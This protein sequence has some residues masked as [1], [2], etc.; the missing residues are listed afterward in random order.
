MFDINELHG[1]EV[2]VDMPVGEKQEQSTKE[3]EVYTRV[4]VSDAPTTIEEITLAQTLIQIKSAKPKVVTTSTTTTTTTMPKARGKQ[5]EEANIA[6]I[7]SWDNTQAMMEADFEL[8]QRLQIEEQ[9]EIT[10][11]ER[12]RLYKHNQLKSKSFEEIQ[13][14]FDNEMSRVNTFIPMD[15]EEVKSKKGTE[16]SSKGTEDEQKSDKSKKAKSSREKAKGIRKKMLGKKR[17]R[18][19]QQQE[20]SKRQRMEDDKETDEHEEVKKLMKLV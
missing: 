15:S 3:R 16:E 18:K 1:D 10:I 12:S 19:E 20:S 17:A 8:A 2:V 9:G 13:K 4:E 11:K 7:E 6:L 5:E 14:L